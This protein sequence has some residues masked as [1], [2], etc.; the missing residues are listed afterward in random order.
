MKLTKVNNRAVATPRDVADAARGF[1]TLG[2]HFHA[3]D[4]PRPSF[5]DEQ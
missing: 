1:S 5:A 3:A 4:G 2:L